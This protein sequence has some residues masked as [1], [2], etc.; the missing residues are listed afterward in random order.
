[1]AGRSKRGKSRVGTHSDSGRMA[2]IGDVMAGLGECLPSTRHVHIR[3]FSKRAVDVT[4]D[5][6]GHRPTVD[7]Q[8]VVRARVRA[9]R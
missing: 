5:R 7:A 6:C 3:G 9:R 4:Q 2:T 8:V 1:M